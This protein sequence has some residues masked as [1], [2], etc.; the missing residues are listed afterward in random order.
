[1][2]LEPAVDGQ[3][4]FVPP[5]PPARGCFEEGLGDSRK[6]EQFYREQRHSRELMVSLFITK[7]EGRGPVLGSLR[8]FS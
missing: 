4:G 6:E 7:M 5:R 8:S 1:M 2:G 3:G